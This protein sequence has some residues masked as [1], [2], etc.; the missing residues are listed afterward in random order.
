M[1]NKI[2]AFVTGIIAI[3]F[4]AVNLSVETFVNDPDIVNGVAT[5]LAGLGPV[6]GAVLSIFK[7]KAE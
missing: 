4:S 1:S 6:I 2:F 7:K 3:L 5:T